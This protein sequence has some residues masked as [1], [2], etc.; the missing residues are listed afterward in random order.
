MTCHA[1]QTARRFRQC[2]AGP[3]GTGLQRGCRLS[4]HVHWC[5]LAEVGGERHAPRKPPPLS[6]PPPCLRLGRERQ[7]SSA[8]GRGHEALRP[9]CPTFTGVRKSA[10]Y[11]FI[12]H[13]S[14]LNLRF[15]VYH[16][17]FLGVKKVRCM[18]TISTAY[19]L[20]S[21]STVYAHDIE[22]SGSTTTKRYLKR[23]L[24]DKSSA[25]ARS[26]F[27]QLPPASGDA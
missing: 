18:T 15:I 2:R 5:H 26:S 10:H 8:G 21:L 6:I 27:V 3:L 7:P 20:Q 25:G 12:I 17:G 22:G 16:V 4:Q 23:V 11:L 19:R 24:V 13:H 14:Q 9:S 1:G